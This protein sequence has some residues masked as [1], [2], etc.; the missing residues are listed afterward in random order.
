MGLVK[1]YRWDR[2]EALAVAAGA[3]LGGDGP[4]SV[5][6]DGWGATYRAERVFDADGQGGLV[7]SPWV[8]YGWEAA[9]WE[10]NPGPMV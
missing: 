4:T 7:E 2:A 1:G 8:A 10:S 6:V 5:S 3:G 9:W